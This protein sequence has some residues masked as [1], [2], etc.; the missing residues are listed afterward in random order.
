MWRSVACGGVWHVEECQKPL[1]TSSQPL[2][3]RNQVALGRH[4]SSVLGKGV[5]LW[6]RPLLGSEPE[7]R[8]FLP[9]PLVQTYLQKP[10][11]NSLGPRDLQVY[12]YLGLNDR[13]PADLYMAAGSV[14]T[15]ARVYIKLLPKDS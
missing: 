11:P 10:F 9:W 13:R 12:P 8:C 4:A 1:F 3:C 5:L 2:G 14:Y 15:W 7:A 6:M